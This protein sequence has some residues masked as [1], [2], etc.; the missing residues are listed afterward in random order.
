MC[1]EDGGTRRLTTAEVTN[2]TS[3]LVATGT[4]IVARLPG[5]PA[6]RLPGCPAA[7][8]GGWAAL[9]FAAEADQRGQ[10]AANLSP[11]HRPVDGHFSL[12]HGIHSCLAAALARLETRVALEET[13]RRFKIWDIDHG[14]VRMPHTSTVRGHDRLSVLL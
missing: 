14:G 3:L 7:R 13:L 9:E 1:T 5:C 10:L 11:L 6:A 12:G 8:L 4:E 2:V